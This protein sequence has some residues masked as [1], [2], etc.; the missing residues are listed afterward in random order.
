MLN[1]VSLRNFNTKGASIK[2]KHRH[3]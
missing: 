1:K 2:D 3:K